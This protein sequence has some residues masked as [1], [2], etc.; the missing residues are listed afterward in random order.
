M[1]LKERNRLLRIRKVKNSQRPTFARYESWR[2]VKLK[3]SGWRKQR[4]I[5][6]KT[7]RKMKMGVKSPEP[8]YRN[9][10]KVRGL[11]PSGLEDIRIMH[12]KDLENLDPKQHGIR[13]ARRLG[14]RK[15]IALIEE[16]RDRGFHILNIGI[17]KEDLFDL[18]SAGLDDEELDTEE[19][20]EDLSRKA[21][22]KKLKRK[23]ENAGEEVEEA[24][25]S[26]S[27]DGEDA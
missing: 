3:K 24:E 26:D 15:K 5:D 25:D 14:G 16:A 18:E 13:I 19:E 21:Q 4:G 9:P 27:E 23:Q 7:R 2:Y 20:E 10:K 22:I 6:N 1:E 17:S 8:G 12:I 11:H